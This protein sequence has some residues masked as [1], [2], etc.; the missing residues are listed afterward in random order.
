MLDL[1]QVARADGSQRNLLD[2]SRNFSKIED[3]LYSKEILE[4]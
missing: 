4:T 2:F 1:A 3:A